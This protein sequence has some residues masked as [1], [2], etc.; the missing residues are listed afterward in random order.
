MLGDLSLDKVCALLSRLGVAFFHVEFS[1]VHVLYL[2]RP[3]DV[4]KDEVNFELFE[5]TQLLLAHVGMVEDLVSLV[6]QFVEFYHINDEF[7]D[8]H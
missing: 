1:S 8:W 2:A 6:S 5:V 7:N 3:Q 4:I